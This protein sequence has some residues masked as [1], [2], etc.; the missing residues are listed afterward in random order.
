MNWSEIKLGGTITIDFI[1]GEGT[2][3]DSLPSCSVFENVTDT[4]MHTPTVVKRTGQPGHYRTT[5]NATTANGYDVG[6]SYNVVASATLSLITGKSIIA[7]FFVRKVRSDDLVLE[8]G[9]P[10]AITAA[11]VN[12]ATITLATGAG[13]L[14]SGALVLVASPAGWQTVTV[15]SSSTL[16]GSS[17]SVISPVLSLTHT[18]ALTTYVAYSGAG[19]LT[20]PPDVTVSAIA[21][22]QAVG[23]NSANLATMLTEITASLQNAVVDLQTD[24]LIGEIRI[25][26]PGTAQ[27]LGNLLRTL[28]LSRASTSDPFSINRVS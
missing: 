20:T 25:Y 26:T 17:V 1:V 11:S 5:I 8:A 22:R 10:Q 19:A 28:P 13:L 9:V 6:S 7:S 12:P 16:G 18:A 24:K 15:L 14:P 2:D 27:I 3:A 23:L 21:I 4:A